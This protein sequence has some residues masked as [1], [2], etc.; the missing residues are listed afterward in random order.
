MARLTNDEAWAGPIG[1]VFLAFGTIE[2]AVFI[3]LRDVP[4]SEIHRTARRLPLGVR[5][6]LLLEILEVYE[7][8]AHKALAKC[9]GQVRSLSKKRN[10]PAHNGLAIHLSGAEE[11][12]AWTEMITSPHDPKHRLSLDEVI[13]LASSAEALASQLHKCL[14]DIRGLQYVK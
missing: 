9:L 1:R 2:G 8:D 7:T 12:F 13:E 4:S 6:E 14:A 3:A 10:I 11:N 5:L